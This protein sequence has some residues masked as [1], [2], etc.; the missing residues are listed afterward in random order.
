MATVKGDVRLN[1]FMTKNL[2]MITQ[3][4]NMTVAELETMQ[5]KVGKDV[6]VSGLNRIRE[7]VAKVDIELESA[8]VKQE[9][10][11]D[12]VMATAKNYGNLGNII[13]ATISAIGI[14]K[15]INLSDQNTQI[16]ARLKI[17]TGGTEEDVAMLQ[18]KIFASAQRSRADYFSTADVVS[19]LGMRAGEAFDNDTD[20]IIQFSENLNKM[21][22]VAGTSQAEMSSASLQ[23]T[24]ALGAGVLRGEEL[25]AVF[26][27]A[28]NVIQK[29]ADYLDQPIGKIRELASDGKITA[30]VVKNAILSSTREINEEFE[31]IPV[32]WEQAWNSM[33]NIAL[34]F[35]QPVLKGIAWLGSHIQELMPIIIGFG[36]AFLVF[37]LA[38]NWTTIA[39]IAT[40]AYHA[41]IGFLSIGFGILTGNTAAASAAVFKFNSALLASPVTW[42]VMVLAV[43]A[44]VL[45]YLWNTNDKVAYGMLF[46]WDNFL[47][48]LQ[49]V[50]LGIKAVFYGVIDAINYMKIGG[51]AIIDGFINSVV[52]LINGFINMLNLIPGVS[53]EP[54]TWQST[55]AMDAANEFAKEKAER[56]SELA[57]DALAIYNRA[58]E[59]EK[60]RDE[61]VENRAK[62][63][64]PG[65]VDELFDGGL[66][67]GNVANVENIEG[68][69]DVASE[70]LKL[71]R[72]LAE[73]QHIQNYISNAPVVYVTTGDINENADADYL[74]ES[75]ATRLGE[76]IDSSMEGVPVK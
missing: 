30:D 64:L 68:E 60:S 39:T 41:V 9:K 26:E 37:Q 12:E 4:V 56:D 52:L 58:Q 74:V 11:N 67:V 72:E 22:V 62:L 45:I 42:F 5:K 13:K 57:D 61:R 54:I 31:E 40:G 75:V 44:G 47:I 59:L 33:S 18:D 23:L 21:F 24:Q 32:T 20:Q 51:L 17:M 35:L 19:K 15:L 50:G 43:L 1:D 10:L 27:A 63:D 53:I 49:L 46:A 76:E 69:V 25:N 3:A 34:R 65:G 16:S 28:P 29:I 73:Q 70:D 36:A 55:L 71:I 48:G 38:A 6:D 66:D 8:I 2:R 14:N 7:T